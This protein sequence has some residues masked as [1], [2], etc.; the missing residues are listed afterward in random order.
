MPLTYFEQLGKESIM[1][2]IHGKIRS[3]YLMK[4]GFS[5][6]KWIGHITVIPQILQITYT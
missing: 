6:F 5:D 2:Q 3:E 1:K 4:S